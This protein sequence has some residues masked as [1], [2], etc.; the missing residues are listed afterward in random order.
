VRIPST[1]SIAF[2]ALASGAAT[3]EIAQGARCTQGDVNEKL[4]LQFCCALEVK[5]HERKTNVNRAAMTLH[6]FQTALLIGC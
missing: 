1:R 2:K 6:S 3:K 4:T 5:R